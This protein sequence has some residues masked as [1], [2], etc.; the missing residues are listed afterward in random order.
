MIEFMKNKHDCE[1]NENIG[2]EEEISLFYDKK[3]FR[4]LFF[5]KGKVF[6]RTFSSKKILILFGI[7]FMIIFDFFLMNRF[8][9]KKDVLDIFDIAIDNINVKNMT[10]DG[11]EVQITGSVVI[12]SLKANSILIRNLWEFG[13]KLVKRVTIYPSNVSL[14]FP[15]YLEKSIVV[16]TLPKFNIDIQNHHQTFFNESTFV[17]FGNMEPFVSILKNYFEIGLHDLKVSGKGI[18]H[19][20]PSYFPVFRTFIDK[21]VIIPDLPKINFYKM[22]DVDSITL[23]DSSVYNAL[24]ARI[25]LSKKIDF[26]IG[27]P[28]S[29]LTWFLSIPSCNQIKHIKTAEIASYFYYNE[30]NR[31][32]NVTLVVHILPFN[33]ELLE[34]CHDIEMSPLNKLV[35]DYFSEK[36]SNVY[37]TGNMSRTSM[38]LPIPLWLSQI[39]AHLEVPVPLPKPFKTDFIKSVKIDKF[40]L[41]YGKRYFSVKDV[42]PFPGFVSDVTIKIEFPYASDFYINITNIRFNIDFLDNNITFSRMLQ[43]NWIPSA[44]VRPSSSLLFV[45]TR[46]YDKYFKIL[47]LTTFN[48]V[49]KKNIFQGNKEYVIYIKGN[50]SARLDCRLGAFYLEGIPISGNVSIEH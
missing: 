6:K 30:S 7:I 19:L 10:E 2:F 34:V 12:D 13:T 8:S 43:S 14:W 42:W 11:I 37:I 47:D 39:L 50:V 17:K 49:L 48:K 24:E 25:Q 35:F 4:D 18:F 32:F 16:I 22:F 44:S 29:Y 45:K 41:T 26:P 33:N 27:L 28:F 20:Q 46:V 3:Y 1:D 5:K 36:H 9:L 40:M 23:N 31:R 38:Q 21:T 15:D